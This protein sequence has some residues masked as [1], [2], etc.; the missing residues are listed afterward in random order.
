MILFGR[1]FLPFVPFWILHYGSATVYVTRCTLDAVPGYRFVPFVFS[2]FTHTSPRATHALIYYTR[3]TCAHA[4]IT[5]LHAAHITTHTL[6]PAAFTTVT[7]LPARFHSLLSHRA[8]LRFTCTL[9]PAPP[10]YLHDVP[11]TF[12][13]YWLRTPHAFVTHCLLRCIRSH[14]FFSHVCVPPRS[15][16]HHVT[17]DWSRLLP[18]HCL[19]CCSFIHYHVYRTRC[20]FSLT[21]DVLDLFVIRSIFVTVDFVT[22][23]YRFVGSVP[24]R[25]FHD[26]TLI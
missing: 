15:C 25:S 18:L 3:P 13:A 10:G 17:F 9:P 7:C 26:V 2:P 12:T 24:L 1:S 6:T 8:L 16:A 22:G 11:S 20:I 14:L 4:C 21:V 5:R 23:R 19:R